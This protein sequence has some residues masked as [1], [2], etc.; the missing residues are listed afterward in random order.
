M[1]EIIRINKR[2]V[3]SIVS[4]VSLVESGFFELD[5]AISVNL[6]RTDFDIGTGFMHNAIAVSTDGLQ[7][8]TDAALSHQLKNLQYLLCNGSHDYSLQIVA[9]GGLCRVFEILRDGWRARTDWM[10]LNG[11]L[12]FKQIVNGDLL[13][14]PY[15][16]L[17]QLFL[18]DETTVLPVWLAQ[19]DNLVREGISVSG[20]E[21]SFSRNGPWVDRLSIDV[22]P[23]T[24]WVRKPAPASSEFMLLRASC[25]VFL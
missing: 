16:A 12:H 7:F 8:Y 1:L 2:Q 21:V 5:A 17:Y 15:G 3:G 13:C 23:A 19:T 10:F 9:N 6:S 11:L 14:V 25:S 18:S 24:L 4:R 20:L 22:L